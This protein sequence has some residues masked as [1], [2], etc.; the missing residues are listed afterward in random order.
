MCVVKRI[1]V[2]VKLSRGFIAII[3]SEDSEK[4]NKHNWWVLPSLNTQYAAAKIKGRCVLMHRFIVSAPLGTTMDHINGNG[5]DNRKGN[6]RYATASQNAANTGKPTITRCTS[7]YKGVSLTKEPW[8]RKRWVAQIRV[9]GKRFRWRCATEREA[10]RVYDKVA[11]KHF[12]E[13]A[14]LNFDN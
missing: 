11:K 9:N 12:G 6:L 13:Y 2:E 7:I 10:A 14:R 5:L 4:I 8:R 1:A 3:D